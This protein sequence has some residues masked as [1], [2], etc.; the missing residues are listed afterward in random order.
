M[1]YGDAELRG[2]N[3]HIIVKRC[4]GVSVFVKEPVCVVHTKVFKVEKTM[5]VVLANQLNEPNYKETV[6]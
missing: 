3:L 5:R 6:R 2:E 4:M 1:I